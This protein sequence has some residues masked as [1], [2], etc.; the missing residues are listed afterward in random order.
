MQEKMLD[1]QI[2]YFEDCEKLS[3]N[4]HSI[5]FELCEASR[6]LEKQHQAILCDI[7]I[8]HFGGTASIAR[9]C[10]LF[11]NL[12]DKVVQNIGKWVGLGK[13]KHEC[14]N[15]D[16]KNTSAIRHYEYG[17][18]PFGYNKKTGEVPYKLEYLE[19]LIKLIITSPIGTMSNEL[20][21]YF[22]RKLNLAIP[23]WCPNHHHG[24]GSPP[25]WFIGNDKFNT[26]RQKFGHLHTEKLKEQCLNRF[27]AEHGFPMVCSIEKP[28]DLYD[29]FEILKCHLI[30]FRNQMMDNNR[31]KWQQIPTY[32]LYY[33]QW[34][35]IF[36]RLPNAIL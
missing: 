35:A 13:L 30:R 21:D 28:R 27:E 2:K 23:P 22:G 6:V 25:L 16:R 5:S 9:D 20:F 34:A 17:G 1:K 33:Q 4:T 14:I 18:G 31:L 36:V 7:E 3:Q 8:I 15:D 29:Q 11:S 12:L 10:R 32:K 24:S 19:Q 26:Y